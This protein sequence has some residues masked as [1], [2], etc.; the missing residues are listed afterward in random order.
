[1][2]QGRIFSVICVFF[3][4]VSMPSCDNSIKEKR[5]IA[6][7]RAMADTVGFAREAWQMDSITHR[8]VRYQGERLNTIFQ[9]LPASS[10]DPWKVIISPHDDYSYVGY[11][12]PAALSYLKAKTIIIFGVCHKARL[13]GLEDVLV[14]D[15]FEKWQSAYGFV[16]VSEFRNRIRKKLP[17]DYYVINDSVQAIEH[18]VEALLPFI[19]QHNKGF[20]LISILVPSMSY[21]RMGEI[22]KA[23]AET[24]YNLMRKENMEWGKDIAFAISS[25]AVHYG[26]EGWGGEN[27]A[28]YGAD[29]I[30]YVDAVTHDL[31]IIDN[32]LLGE[33]TPKKIELFT[34]YTVR[35]GDHK[36]YKWTCCGRY[37]IPFGLLTSYY[38]NEQLGGN[39][40]LQPLTGI[41]IGYATSI[42]HESLFVDDLLMGVTAPAYLRHWVGYAA[43]GYK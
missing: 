1:M 11:L 10:K 28:F 12:Y 23:L 37:S 21:D 43:V 15:D 17:D 8:I 42:D 33:L 3:I 16:K 22:S 7:T 27:F 41:E 34:D 2:S 29:S 6:K 19:Q 30:G 4:V 32:C 5:R 13:F 9:R 40:K 14:F 39:K 24:I 26:D 38:L 25:D 18:S 20:E 36:A 31:E 35:Q